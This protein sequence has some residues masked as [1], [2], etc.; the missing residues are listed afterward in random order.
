MPIVLPAAMVQMPLQQPE[1]AVQ[2]SP[3]WRQND[4]ALQR[5]LKQRPEQQSALDVHELLS[6][7]QLVFSG[8]HVPPVH[9]PLQQPEFDVQAAPSDVHLP[10]LHTPPV[11][12][13]VQ[14][15]LAA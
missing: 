15:S 5:P 11:H 1:L 3:T 7:L 9:V 12:T 13:P 14:Q 4:D 6:V 10:R 8:V 2:A